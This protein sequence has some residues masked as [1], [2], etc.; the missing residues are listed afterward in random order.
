[1]LWIDLSPW[2]G[3]VTANQNNVLQ[4][5]HLYPL[6]KH[7]EGCG[8]FH[9]DS[10]PPI[11]RPWGLTEWIEENENDVNHT[12]WPSHSPH[13]NPVDHLWEC[14]PA[15]FIFSPLLSWK[16]QEGISFERAVVHLPFLVLDTCITM[17][18]C[19]QKFLAA[20]CLLRW[21]L[22]LFV[23]LLCHKIVSLIILGLL[24]LFLRLMAI[25]L[26]CLFFN[27]AGSLGGYGYINI[28]SVSDPWEA[29]NTEPC[30]QMTN[31]HFLTNW[32]RVMA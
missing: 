2:N 3:I 5:D 1:M 10:G 13:L 22:L 12:I 28:S 17:Q 26:S 20:C 11:I 9:D 6:M 18:R 21:F 19:T 14:S 25:P 15:P 4:T 8:L 23:L 7:P 27:R 29:Q 30:K 32:A 31:S 24:H 16:L